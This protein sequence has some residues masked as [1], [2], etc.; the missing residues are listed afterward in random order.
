M[1]DR[2][3]QLQD[4]LDE[5]VTLLFPTLSSPTISLP[6]VRPA[7]VLKIIKL[8]TQFYA[9]IRYISTNHPSSTLSISA[10]GTTSFTAQHNNNASNDPS[11]PI[12]QRSPSAGAQSPP[13][14][15]GPDV[16]TQSASQSQQQSSRERRKSKDK[17][18]NNNPPPPDP[19]PNDD[20]PQLPTPEQFQRDQHELARDL[21]L[22]EKQIE[23]LISVLPGIGTSEEEQRERLKVL[24]ERLDGVIRGLRRV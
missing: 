11:N 7:N 16:S 3:T 24:L 6:H 23:I 19:E 17:T 14:L 21:I 15:P 4:A 8:A 9:S 10:D 5:V 2:L 13:P 12:S 20:T 18:N 22:K 1:T